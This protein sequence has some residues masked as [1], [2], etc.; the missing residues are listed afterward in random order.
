MGGNLMATQRPD[1]STKAKGVLT[2]AQKLRTTLSQL[3]EGLSAP[4]TADVRITQPETV[5]LEAG[6]D[7]ELII[8]L[9]GDPAHVM[10]MADQLSAQ[11]CG[12]SS[13]GNSSVSCDCSGV[14]A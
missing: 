3:G 9:H 2:A 6:G 14:S 12:C 10:E 4:L 1:L 5:A 13:I 8:D 11:G 7:H